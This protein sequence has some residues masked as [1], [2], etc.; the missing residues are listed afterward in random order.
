MFTCIVW[1]RLQTQS[2]HIIRKESVAE[3]QMKNL[4]RGKRN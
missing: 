1:L 2:K 4:D 3:I